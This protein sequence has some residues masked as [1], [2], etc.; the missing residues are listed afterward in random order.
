M[1]CNK[2]YLG[3]NENEYLNHPNHTETKFYKTSGIHVL[4]DFISDDEE[5]YLIKYLDSLPWNMSQ[6]GRRKQVFNKMLCCFIYYNLLLYK[7]SIFF[8]SL[9]IYI[10][11]IFRI[12]DRTVI[13]K[14]VN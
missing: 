12:L 3:S 10:F 4:L 7:Y 8:L 2:A 9:K 14:N 6:S 13:L 1:Y 5:S 11:L